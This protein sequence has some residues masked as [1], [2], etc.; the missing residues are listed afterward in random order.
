MTEY[1]PM[2]GGMQVKGT[3]PLNAGGG[4]VV[5]DWISLQLGA[6]SAGYNW[7]SFG[8]PAQWA[9]GVYVPGLGQLGAN[10]NN[11]IKLSWATAGLGMYIAAEDYR[12]RA[13]A[14]AAGTNGTIPDIVGGLS[15]GAGPIGFQV[16]AGWHDG[17][18]IDSYGINGAASID[19]GATGLAGSSLLLAATYS[20]GDGTWINGLAGGGTG[21]TLY[22]ALMLGLTSQFGVLGEVA[23]TSATTTL[24][25]YTAELHFKPV[26]NFLIAGAFQHT[27]ESGANRATVRLQR[28]FP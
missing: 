18:A 11:Y 27:V 20:G 12:G 21:Y 4:P 17:T 16:H 10:K 19:L 7:S 28:N 2:I 13:A 23:Y 8:G 24:T 6:L 9:Q 15:F 25:N 1:G 14:D 3:D 22:G 26:R 5:I